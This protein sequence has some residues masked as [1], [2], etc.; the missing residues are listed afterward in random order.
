MNPF[1]II[2]NFLL[3]KYRN[4][5][6]QV[7]KWVGLGNKQISFICFLLSLFI[8]FEYISEEYQIGYFILLVMMITCITTKIE[9]IFD[10]LFLTLVRFYVLLNFI[11]NSNKGILLIAN[12]FLLVSIIYLVSIKTLPPDESYLLSFLKSL[13]PR[14]R[15]PVRVR[16]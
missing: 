11:I 5:S 14:K 8:T 15:V 2:D 16:K 10:D 13:V 12:N 9:N 4:F 3:E 6:I 7:K 1:D